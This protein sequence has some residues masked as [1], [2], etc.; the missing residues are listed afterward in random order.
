M[1]VSIPVMDEIIKM[2]AKNAAAEILN[3][4]GTGVAEIDKEETYVF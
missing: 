3:A 4:V 1:T 2:S